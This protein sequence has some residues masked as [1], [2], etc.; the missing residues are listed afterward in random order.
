MLLTVNLI[1]RESYLLQILAP[2]DD[3]NMARIVGLVV[4]IIV[5]ILIVVVIAVLVGN[6]RTKPV[7]QG[8]FIDLIFYL[9]PYL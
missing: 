2:S 1:Y 9:H 7:P 8:K 4:G 6:S 5:L 3:S